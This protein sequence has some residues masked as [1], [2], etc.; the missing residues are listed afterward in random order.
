VVDREGQRLPARPCADS[1]RTNCPKVGRG[2]VTGTGLVASHCSSQ[3]AF[4]AAATAICLVATT[5]RAQ[6]DVA[7]DQDR[8]PAT[9]ISPPAPCTAASVR[10]HRALRSLT[11]TKRVRG[12]HVGQPGSVGVTEHRRLVADVRV[13]DDPRGTNWRRPAGD[14][15]PRLTSAATDGRNTMA[16]PD[17]VRSA[18]RTKTSNETRAATG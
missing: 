17:I 9:A 13:A 6:A 4:V 2:P 15:Q 7:L 1:D 18:G 5:Q 8:G 11:T 10:V 3:A 12:R 16:R 14:V